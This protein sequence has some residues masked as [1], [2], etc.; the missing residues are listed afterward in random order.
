MQL[1]RWLRARAVLGVSLVHRGLWCSFWLVSRLHNL[2]AMDGMLLISGCKV[3]PFAAVELG[4]GGR[5]S[6]FV[7]QTAPRVHCGS[8]LIDWS[9]LLILNTLFNE[10][11]V[12]NLVS[13]TMWC[14]FLFFFFFL[15]FWL[16]DVSERSSQRHAR[17][18][19]PRNCSVASTVLQTL[20]QTARV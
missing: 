8:R 11:P 6:Q 18:Y 4:H 16:Q 13:M 7:S 9:M 15:I 12:F 17:A 5:M 2:T 3:N 10:N 20:I 19:S 1:L 14:V